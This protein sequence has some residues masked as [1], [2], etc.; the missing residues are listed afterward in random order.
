VA[1]RLQAVPLSLLAPHRN[2]DAETPADSKVVEQRR[3]YQR[4]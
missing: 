1:A 2:I 3:H 4:D